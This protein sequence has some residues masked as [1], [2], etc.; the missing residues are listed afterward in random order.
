MNTKRTKNDIIFGDIEDIFYESNNNF[1]SKE[2]F[3]N[4]TYNF[5][6]III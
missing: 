4:E 6:D 1:I 2:N 3:Q 5:Y